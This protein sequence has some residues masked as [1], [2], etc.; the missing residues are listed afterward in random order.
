MSLGILYIHRRKLTGRVNK[1]SHVY[2]WTSVR[3]LDIHLQQFGYNTSKCN[4]RNKACI[5]TSP[6]V[7]HLDSLSSGERW[8]A[9]GPLA[10]LSSL[11]AMEHATDTSCM[12]G[13]IT[14]WLVD[15]IF[16]ALYFVII[17][18]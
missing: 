7:R 13:W 2:L 9:Q 12:A 10:A 1:Q 14:G 5:Q 8:V 18:I 15:F 17:E 6:H 11:R 4:F 16:S 3:K